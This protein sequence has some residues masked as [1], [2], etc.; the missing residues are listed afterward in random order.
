M[1]RHAA[2]LL[3]LQPELLALITAQLAMEDNISLE[4]TSIALR[5]ALGDPQVR[6]QWKWHQHRSRAK[7]SRPHFNVCDT[8]NWKIQVPGAW[9]DLCMQMD[10][11]GLLTYT[12]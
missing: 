4:R 9:G 12:R 10:A 5:K 8:R 3:D 11:S 6:T 1:T 2:G 7:F